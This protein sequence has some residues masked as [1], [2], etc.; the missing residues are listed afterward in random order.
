MAW[1]GGRRGDRPAFPQHYLQHLPSHLPHLPLELPSFL[2]LGRG[3]TLPFP[4]TFMGGAKHLGNSFIEL[5]FCILWEGG[6][7]NYQLLDTP[8]CIVL[9]EGH[10]HTFIQ[11]RLPMPVLIAWVVTCG[12]STLVPATH[13]VPTPHNPTPVIPLPQPYGSAQTPQRVSPAT[14]LLLWFLRP[15]EEFFFPG[16]FSS[17]WTWAR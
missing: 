3:D 15:V 5:L 2:P 12:H 7:K 10:A 6:R 17:F 4:A 13:L 14:S 9:E 1:G 8:P 11:L 16:T